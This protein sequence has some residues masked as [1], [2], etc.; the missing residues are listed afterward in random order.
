MSKRLAERAVL[1][2]STVLSNDSHQDRQFAS[3]APG[4]F[5]S[6]GSI[7]GPPELARMV[8]YMST[9][10]AWSSVLIAST[11]LSN[12]WNSHR[13]PQWQFALTAFPTFDS[14]EGI[15]G[16]PALAKPVSYMSKSLAK[17]ALLIASTV[18]SIASNSHHH[19][20]GNSP[21]PPTPSPTFN[22]QESIVEPLALAETVFYMF[23]SFTESAV[24]IGLI[25]LWNFSGCQKNPGKWCLFQAYNL[26]D[27]PA[28]HPSFQ[29]RV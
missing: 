22:F 2:R 8:F 24:L 27:P 4:A 15:V 14:Q 12:D 9:N 19:R 18:L 10:L 28:L 23:K 17:I 3:I 1:I 26:L 7:G 5:D 11:V 20:S 25:A 29:R 16:P 13:H 6:Q 21:R